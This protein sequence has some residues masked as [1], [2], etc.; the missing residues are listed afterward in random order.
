MVSKMSVFQDA[1]V[2]PAFVALTFDGIAMIVM[3]IWIA[4]RTGQ[5]SKSRPT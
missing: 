3:T 1:Q 5:K 4:V 2:W